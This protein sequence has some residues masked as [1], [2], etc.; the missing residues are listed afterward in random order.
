MSPA[1]LALLL[2]APPARAK[3]RPAPTPAPAADAGE[4]ISVNFQEADLADVLLQLGALSGQS[5]VVDP[6]VRGRVTLSLRDVPVSQ[7]VALVAARNG[8][9]VVREREILRVGPL[10]KLIAHP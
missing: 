3:A 1:L 9:G 8:L 2:L 10:P 6:E 7:V 4:A 5:V